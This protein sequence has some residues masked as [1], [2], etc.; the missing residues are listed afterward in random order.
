M[1]ET[2]DDLNLGF[3]AAMRR[4][5]ST[6]NVISICVG[7]QPMGIT[8]TAMSSLSLDPPSLLIC[9]NRSASMHASMEDVAHFRVNVLHRDQEDIARMFADRRDHALRFV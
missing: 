4:V 8:A 2:P 3:R 6:V 9:I 5:A 1:S 7:D